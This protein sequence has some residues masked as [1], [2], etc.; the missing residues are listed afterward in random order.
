MFFIRIFKFYILFLI[1]QEKR[2]LIPDDLGKDAKTVAA[3]Q[4]RHANFEHDLLTLGTQV[5][6]VKLNSLTKM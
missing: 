2:I 6:V 3:L 5:S 1:L 4:R